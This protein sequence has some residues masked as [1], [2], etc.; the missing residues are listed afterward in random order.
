MKK[1]HLKKEPSY[2]AKMKSFLYQEQAVEFVK[3]LE[4]S[5]IFHEQGLGKTK[6]AIDILLYWIS[7][8][9]I[10]TVL[11]VT[12]KQ[13]IKNWMDE[14]NMH[15]YLHPKILTNNRNSNFYVFNSNSRLL[16]TN[17]ETLAFEK[18]RFELFLK[19]RNVG[20][21]I[22][23]SAKLKNPDSKLTKDFFEL[24]G[25]FKRKIIMS[26]TP[27]ANRPYDIWAQVFFLDSGK[28]LGTNFRDF[29]KKADLSN[30][31]SENLENRKVFEDFISNVYSKISAF[32]IRE[33]KKQADLSLPEKN[34]IDIWTM[35]SPKQEKLYN[36]LREEL[37]IEVTKKGELINDDSSPILKR[38]MRLEQITSNPKLI[39]ESVDYVSGKEKQL[40]LLLK[41]IISREEKVIIWT[42]YIENVEY[43]Y[44][45]YKEYGTEK[46]H[47]RLSME[48]RNSAISNFKYG[49]SKILIATPQ[50][51]KEGLTLTVANNAIFYDRGLSLD[52]YLQAQDR[53]HRIS[54]KKECNIYNIM[55]RGSIDEW[56][57]A[58]LKSKKRAAELTQNDIDIKE[59]E[60]VA[61]YTYD[62]LIKKVLGIGDEK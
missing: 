33:T 54:Q 50:S 30:D 34:Y 43:F 1:I 35:F 2:E 32:S 55:I 53:I 42:N 44:E 38:I 26:G 48:L 36:K 56:I 9:E 24:S 37:I 60:N 45:K 59:Y 12:K 62:K 17:F 22:D 20:V 19:S 31:L 18:K 58:L 25:L 6:I 4:Y 40:S 41:T 57:D 5:A 47:G 61:D 14:M 16:I 7:E 52:D 29:K 39:D 15:T 23:E 11:I 10:D 46:V 28:S 8:K 3:D 13:L 21:I 51:A 49:E 27:V